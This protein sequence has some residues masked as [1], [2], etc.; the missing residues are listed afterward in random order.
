MDVTTNVLDHGFLAKAIDDHLLVHEVGDNITRCRAR[1][2]DPD[3]G[4]EGAGAH[5]EGAV[6]QEVEGIL[7][8]VIPLARRTDVVG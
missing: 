6:E 1:H 5:H 7:D 8:H 2:V 3:A 4:E